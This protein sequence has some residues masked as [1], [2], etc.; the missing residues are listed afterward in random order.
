VQVGGECKLVVCTSGMCVGGQMGV[1]YSLI[2]RSSTP[3]VFYHL[4]YAKKM[5]GIGLGNFIT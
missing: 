3:P 4:Q 2:S 5:V 1:M